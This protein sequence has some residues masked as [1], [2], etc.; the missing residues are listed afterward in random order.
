MIKKQINLFKIALGFFTRIPCKYEYSQTGLNKSNRYFPIIGMVVGLIAGAVFFGANEILPKSVAILLSMIT[1]ILVTGAFHED[2]FAD[3]CDGFGGGWTKVRILDIMKD[4]RIGA[5]GVT[6]L[7]GILSLKFILLYEISND[8]I[9]STLIIGH[10]ISRGM[11]VWTMKSLIYVRDDETSKVKPIAK[12]LNVKDFLIAS[13]FSLASLFL[14]KSFYI[15]LLFIPL[16]ITKLWLE[17]WFKKWIGGYT[18]DCLGTLQQ[19]SEIVIYLS[20]LIINQ[21]V[22]HPNL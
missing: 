2:G 7:I 16:L 22:I 21:N 20:I 19:V 9:I 14:Y 3:V 10:T 18:G 15:L 8:Q 12:Q 6:G 5:Y 13:M 11:A 4:S 1:T 17:K